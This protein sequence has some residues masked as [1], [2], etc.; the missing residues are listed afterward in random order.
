MGSNVTFLDGVRVGRGCVIAAGTIVRGEIPAYSVVAGVPGRVIKSRKE[1]G[2]TPV[3]IAPSL[4][5]GR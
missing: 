1:E 4:V 3:S 2:I 5:S